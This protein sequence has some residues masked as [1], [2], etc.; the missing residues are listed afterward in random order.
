MSVEG[1]EKR[2]RRLEERICGMPCPVSDTAEKVRQQLE[3]ELLAAFYSEHLHTPPHAIKRML[4][5]SEPSHGVHEIVGG[6]KSFARSSSEGQ[7]ERHD[8][9]L[10]NFAIT[11]VH[12]PGRQSLGLHA[13]N[14]EI[15]F[16][17][18]YPEQNAPRFVRFDLNQ[19]GHGNSSRGMRCHLHPGHDDLQVPSALL[20]P[21]EILELFLYGLILPDRARKK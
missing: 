10:F 16:P 13:Y 5:L 19:P 17:A 6:H 18:G 9:A 14:F 2:A 7:F 1:A 20:A 21:I 8:G 3:R 12:R 4:K 15:L 11:V